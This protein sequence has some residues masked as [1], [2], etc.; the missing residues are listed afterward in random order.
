MSERSDDREL[1]AL[2]QSLRGLKPDAGTLDRATLMYRAGRA[3]ARG[4][5][6]PLATAASL[7]LAAALAVLL[8]TRPEPPVVE[9]VV[10]LP[11]PPAAP[12]TSPGAEESPD[13]AAATWSY[14]LRLQEDVLRKGLEGVPLPPAAPPP[15]R[16]MT[17]EQ[18]LQAL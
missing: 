11:A 17:A 8:L 14:Y 13:P 18:L 12:E 10:Y 2:E 5:G 15:A 4:R 7:A 16:P 9:R 3:S 6:W 1:T